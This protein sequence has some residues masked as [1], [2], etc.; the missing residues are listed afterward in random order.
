MKKSGINSPI[1]CRKCGH[2]IGYVKLKPKFNQKIILWG[3]IFAIATEIIAQII[4]QGILG[5]NVGLLCKLAI[6][7]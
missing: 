3:A 7:C 5:S 2:K 6:R 1:V 4:A